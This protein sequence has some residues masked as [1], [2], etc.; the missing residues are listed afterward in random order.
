MQSNE[1]LVQSLV[2]Q[3]WLKT[4]RVIAAFRA[5]D[6]ADFVPPERR[7][8]AYLNTAL[9][10]GSG[11]TISQ[12]L[13]VAFMFELLQP[14]PGD[15]ILD[16]GA[17]SG[18]TTALLAHIVSRRSGAEFEYEN[19]QQNDQ[20]RERVV[21]VEAVPALAEFGRKNV[22]AYTY[23]ESGIVVFHEG[24]GS[25][26]WPEAAPFDGILAGAT[27]RESVPSEWKEQI[28]NDGC[29]VAP[30]DNNIVRLSRR[31]D[32]TFSD[33]VWPGFAFVPLIET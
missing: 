14:A 33:E 23:I 6:R 8:E 24:D 26:G 3:G 15:A 5:I 9:P 1:E 29:I 18:W 31:A 17:G 19:P 20:K 27:A 4:P 11:Q 2:S 25:R 21:A 32:G 13:V 22:A 28:T 16:V 10:I 30:V 7:G 12:P